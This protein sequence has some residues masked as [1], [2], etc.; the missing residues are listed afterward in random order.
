[1]GEKGYI[2]A[3]CANK[4]DLFETQE[5]PDEEG[6]KLAEKYNIKFNSTSALYNIKG[7]RSFLYELIKDYLGLKDA[8]IEEIE[9]D[10]SQS[11]NTSFKIN[12]KKIKL[13]EKKGCC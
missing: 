5:V 1:M 10:N 6:K 8:V 13:E 4:S 9:N 12:N 3:L 7:F 11:N 2:L